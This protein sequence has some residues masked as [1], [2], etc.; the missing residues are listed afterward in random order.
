M[1]LSGKHIA[2]QRFLF[3]LSYTFFPPKRIYSIIFCFW[4]VSGNLKL[5]LSIWHI[6]VFPPPSLSPSHVPLLSS[7]YGGKMQVGD[8]KMRK[9]SGLGVGGLWLT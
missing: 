8:Q 4:E 5:I 9:C 6:F 7:Q 2:L 3:L 1:E